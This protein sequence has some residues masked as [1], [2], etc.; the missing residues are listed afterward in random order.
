MTSPIPSKT[1]N[2]LKTS[3]CNSFTSTTCSLSKNQTHTTK[4][5]KKSEKSNK[6]L[7]IDLENLENK[8][9]IIDKDGRNN[10]ENWAI[11]KNEKVNNNG[12]KIFSKM[13]NNGNNTSELFR[14]FNSRKYTSDLPITIAK[15]KTVNICGMLSIFYIFCWFIFGIF[16]YVIAGLHGDLICNE[17]WNVYKSC[18]QCQM[19]QTTYQDW[20]V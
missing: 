2:S 12:N 15:S 11:T 1:N 8:K 7:T 16:W 3:S 10:L 17:Y 14:Q 18:N 5:S 20:T 4:S 13:K 19:N 6:K 9:R